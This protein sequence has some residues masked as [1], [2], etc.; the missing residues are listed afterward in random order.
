MT[1]LWTWTDKDGAEITVRRVSCYAAVVIGGRGV[2]MPP[3][4]LPA[5]VTALFGAVSGTRMPPVVLDRP[6]VS[7]GAPSAGF[8]GLEVH[9]DG[10]GVH[11]R[12]GVSSV[13]LDR[14][15]ARDLAADIAARADLVAGEPDPAEVTALATDIR[16]FC[17]PSGGGMPAQELAVRLLRAGWRRP[18]GTGDAQ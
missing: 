11:V 15:K 1:A 8:G 9:H 12:L 2:Y 18:D 16:S 7:A 4:V 10:T 17:E 6:E 13:W 3:G 5:F 14:A